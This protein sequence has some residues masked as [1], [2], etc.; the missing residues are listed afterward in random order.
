MAR[1][2]LRI[3][4]RK[5]SSREYQKTTDMKGMKQQTSRSYQDSLLSALQVPERAAANLEVAL[6]AE[7]F[8][9]QVLQA[10]LRDVVEARSRAN[11]LSES[12]ERAHATLEQT[13][14]EHQ[15]AEIQA[16]IAFLDALGLKLI[17]TLK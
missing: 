8:D 16:L 5:E 11:T 14:S 4:L 15:G 9:L 3:R 13:L 1:A 7:D 6:E 2:A 12:A 17:T 10:T